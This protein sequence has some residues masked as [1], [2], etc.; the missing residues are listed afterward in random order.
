[1]TEIAIRNLSGS[2]VDTAPLAEAVRLVLAAE[3]AALPALS[4]ALVNDA[5]ITAL[6]ARF[7]GHNRATDVIAFEPQDGEGEVIISVD[8][9]RKQAADA[10]HSLEDELC[11]LVAH[12]VLHV[13]GYD[14]SGDESRCRMLKRQHEILNI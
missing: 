12:G 8:T 13:L 10:G 1:M 9:A 5:R 4:L 14:D 3:D 2:D 6:N 7:L 11:F